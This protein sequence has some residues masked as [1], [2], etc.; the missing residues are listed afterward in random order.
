M[1]CEANL[2]VAFGTLGV[3]L[4]GGSLETNQFVA[5]P[6]FWCYSAR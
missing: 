4:K 5:M 6:I 3:P 2:L 1:G